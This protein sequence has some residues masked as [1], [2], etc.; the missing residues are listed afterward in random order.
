MITFVCCK[1]DHASAAVGRSVLS[2]CFEH[3]HRRA[4]RACVV[5]RLQG[6]GVRAWALKA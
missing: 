6:D 4:I 3:A 2:D 5:H 1:P